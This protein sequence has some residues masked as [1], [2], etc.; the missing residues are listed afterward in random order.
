MGCW[1]SVP[2]PSLPLPLPPSENAGEE[3]ACVS[4]WLAPN[5]EPAPGASGG[6]SLAS[7]GEPCRA[8]KKPSL[9]PNGELDGEGSPAPEKRCS[10]PKP[11]IVGSVPMLAGK[12]FGGGVAGPLRR[13][14]TVCA[15][16][17]RVRRSG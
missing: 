5:G 3:G 8:G 17:A 13:R 1:P 14:V 15:P 2:P 12:G 7:N 4:A 9:S 6:N 11:D 10:R 16:R